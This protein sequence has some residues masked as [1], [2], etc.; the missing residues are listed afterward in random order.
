M[1]PAIDRRE[2]LRATRLYLIVTLGPSADQWLAPVSAA[3]ASGCIGMVQLRAVGSSESGIRGQVGR[4]RPLC[5]A[6]G[7]LLLLNDLPRLAAE[8]DLDGAHVGQGD[9]APAAARALLGP[10]R[11]LGLSTHDETEIEA[12]RAA[13]LD[14]LGL[15]PCFPTASKALALPPGG[16]A[17]VARCHAAAADRPLFPIGG[18]SPSNAALL[19]GAGAHR[20]A[21]GAGI[22]AAKDPA[23]AARHLDE[24]LPVV[25]V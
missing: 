9:L 19:A 25:Q 5:T 23:A 16:A 12:A 7:A 11:L 2:R 14:Y 17:L 18:I 20:L 24:A 13:P 1:P 3:L 10:E 21:V 4:L 8:L 6:Y 15:G 22:L